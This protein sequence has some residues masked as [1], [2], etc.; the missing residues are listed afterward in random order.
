[1]VDSFSLKNFVGKTWIPFNCIYILSVIGNT[2]IV[3]VLVNSI[4]SIFF[5]GRSVDMRILITVN[6][7]TN[8]KEI[9]RESSTEKN[10]AQNIINRYIINVIE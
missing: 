10:N 6:I 7:V 9:N 5:R 4:G 3:G 8:N 1:M 2:F